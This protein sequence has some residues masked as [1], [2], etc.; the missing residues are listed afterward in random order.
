[1]KLIVSMVL[2]ALLLTLTDL[3]IQLLPDMLTMVVQ[4]GAATAALGAPLMLWLLPKLAMRHQTQTETV[5]T[6]H[7]NRISRLSKSS[8]LLTCSAL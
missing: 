4:T 7:N 3:L 1:P 6:R 8:I 2:G 5:L